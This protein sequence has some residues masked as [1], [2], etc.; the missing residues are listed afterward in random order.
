MKID[1][2]S[3]RS[4]VL[5]IYSIR[6]VLVS[7]ILTLAIAIPTFVFYE[8]MAWRASKHAESVEIIGEQIEIYENTDHLN[9]T[10]TTD[11][12]QEQEE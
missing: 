9:G 3:D 4:A 11:K 2:D 7:L 1:F 8:T 6:S 12:T 10:N 5:V